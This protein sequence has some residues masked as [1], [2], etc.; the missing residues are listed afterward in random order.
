TGALQNLSGNNTYT[1]I[2]TLNTAEVTIGVDSGS[3]LTIGDGNGHGTITDAMKGFSLI[4]ELTGTLVL[5]DADSYGSGTGTFGTS[6]DV[7]SGSPVQFANGT[8]VAQGVLNIQNSNALAGTTSADVTTTTV[9]NGAQLQVQ[10]GINVQNELLRIAG[11]G[12]VVG[13]LS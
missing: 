10:G 6:T 5:A 11:N 3:T 2:L 13:G 7:Q 1:G 4:K 8:L 9:L 12:I